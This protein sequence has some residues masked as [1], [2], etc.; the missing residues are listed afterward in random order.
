MSGHSIR[1]G[2]IH[3]APTS[4][5]FGIYSRVPQ[6]TLSVFIPKY[7]DETYRTIVSKIRFV[8]L[9]CMTNDLTPSYYTSPPMSIYYPFQCPGFFSVRQ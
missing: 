5:P 6:T 8:S 9:Y 3:R 7:F 2:Q 4:I 1:S